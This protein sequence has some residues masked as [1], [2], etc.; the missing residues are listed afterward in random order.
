MAR[1]T[2]TIGVIA[3]IMAISFIASSMGAIEKENFAALYL[4]NESSG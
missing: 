2:L 3:G 4:F 1:L